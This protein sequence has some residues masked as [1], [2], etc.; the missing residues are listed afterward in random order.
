MGM[1]VE[2]LDKKGKSAMRIGYTAD[3]EYFE[4][5]TNTYENCDILIAHIQP[6]KH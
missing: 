4:D 6:A 1:V 5:R 2:L 3:T